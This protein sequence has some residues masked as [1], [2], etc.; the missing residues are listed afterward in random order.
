MTNLEQ[1]RVLD[2]KLVA[3]INKGDE[4]LAD[5]IRD[6]MDPVWYRLTESEMKL[7]REESSKEAVRKPS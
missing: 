2:Q 1:Y 4:A 3:A 7:L 6:E 5:S